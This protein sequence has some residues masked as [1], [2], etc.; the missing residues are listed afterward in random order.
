MKRYLLI[1]SILGV[2]LNQAF[3]VPRGMKL[4]SPSNI[5]VN[6]KAKKIRMEFDLNCEEKRDGQTAD[7]FEW[8]SP[9]LSADDEG[10]VAYAVGVVISTDYD[11]CIESKESH[12]FSWE[13]KPQDYLPPSDKISNWD[14]DGFVPMNLKN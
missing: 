9:V 13:I 6:K 4:V 8:A 11:A 2:F 7:P 14:N 5:V 3:A 10:D 12:H 1:I